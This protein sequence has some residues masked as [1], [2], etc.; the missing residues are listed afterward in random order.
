MSKKWEEHST[1]EKTAVLE[2]VAKIYAEAGHPAG[3]KD[4]SWGGE[5]VNIIMAK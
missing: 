5:Y 1:E 4:P 3:L 2:S